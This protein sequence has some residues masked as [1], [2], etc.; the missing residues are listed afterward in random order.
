MVVTGL[1]TD[2]DSTCPLADMYTFMAASLLY[3]RIFSGAVI[4]GVALYGTALH[5]TGSLEEMEKFTAAATLYLSVPS[6][7]AMARSHVH[8][9]LRWSGS[10][11]LPRIH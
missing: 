11:S 3:S 1:E 7:T 10:P 4:I 9:G 5:S 8:C 2:V 6:G